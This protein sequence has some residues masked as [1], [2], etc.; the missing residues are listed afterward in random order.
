MEQ[1]FSHA[2]NN[3]PLDIHYFPATLP[4]SPALPVT[5][6]QDRMEQYFSQA[7]SDT[8]PSIYITFQQYFSHALSATPLS[9]YILHSSHPAILPSI[10]S[11]SS[12]GGMEQY[13]SQA[14]SE[15]P[16]YI[17]IIFQPP[18]H[19]PQQPQSPPHWMGWR[20]IL[21]KPCPCQ[22]QQLILL[23]Q[24]YIQ[25]YYMWPRRIRPPL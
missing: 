4:S 6:S 16:P 25:L 22:I 18:S 15:I 21:V 10:T 1:Y 23:K 14:R 7:M 2:I 5:S 3:T 9:I 24:P 13:F 11:Y 12:Q 8:L 20:S 17:Y 19:P